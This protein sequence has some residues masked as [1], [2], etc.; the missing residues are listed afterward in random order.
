MPEVIIITVGYH[1]RRL[2]SLRYLA[3]FNRI[4]IKEAS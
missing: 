1:F 2:K 4:K 3:K